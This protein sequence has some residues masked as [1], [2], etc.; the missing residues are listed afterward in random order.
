[1]LKCGGTFPRAALSIPLDHVCTSRQQLEE[2]RAKLESKLETLIAEHQVSMQPSVT[3]VG[4]CAQAQKQA[5]HHKY[6]RLVEARLAALR[7]EMVQHEFYCSFF[8]VVQADHEQ[9]SQVNTG[10]GT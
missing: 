8:K 3:R 9:S 6:Q 10:N 2:S 7:R 5:L 1:M 4:E